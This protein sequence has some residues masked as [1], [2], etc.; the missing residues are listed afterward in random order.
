MS[1]VVR[2]GKH[3]ARCALVCAALFA[4]SAVARA[5]EEEPS[6]LTPTV[7]VYMR[8]DGQPLTFSARAKTSPSAPTWCV[9]PCSA[10]LTPGDYQVKLNGVLADGAVALRKPGTLQGQYHSREASRSGGWLALN[11]GGILGG[12]FITT[13]AL[14]GPS[15]AYVAGGGSLAAGGVIFL[16][17]YRADSAQVSFTP[18]EPLDMRGMPNSETGPAG[19]AAL[20]PADRANFASQARGLGF[21]VMF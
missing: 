12:V 16:L 18:G 6:A 11:V 20:A 10:R 14:G 2:I 7:R 17:S 1:V 19:G 5:D 21:R 4:R 8:S 3:L 13:A 15:W 9:A